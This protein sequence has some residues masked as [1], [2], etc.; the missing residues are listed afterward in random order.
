[1]Y[2]IEKGIELPKQK[3]KGKASI[4][5]YGTMDINDS[6]L[7]T[8]KAF[9]SVYQSAYTFGKRH[10]MKFVV[11]EVPAEGKNSK[12][13]VRVWRVPLEYNEKA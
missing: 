6:F 12:G 7:V 13:G 5:P 8:D 4:Y 2:K 9:K 10:N 11:T 3:R 1:M